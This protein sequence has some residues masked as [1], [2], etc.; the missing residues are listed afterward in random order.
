MK[1]PAKRQLLCGALACIAMSL[2]CHSTVRAQQYPEKLR[3]A[4]RHVPPF[5]IKSKEGNWSGIAIDLWRE[6]ATELDVEYEFKE[7][8]LKSMLARLQSGEVDVA[9]GALTATAK[10]EESIDFTHPFHSSGLGMAV[11]PKKSS[12]VS[13]FSQLLTP[14]VARILGGILVAMLCL[15]VVMYVLERKNNSEQF[16]K[17]IGRG[18]LTGI[19]WA[20]VTMTTVGYGD[21][22]P[23][24]T[25]G[26]LLGTLW[27]FVGIILIAI[28]TGVVSSAL[29]VSKLQSE[30]QGPED[31]P[32]LKIACVQDSTG[33][34]F[35]RHLF[36]RSYANVEEA[37]AAVKSG[38]RG[39]GV[40]DATIL[41][42]LARQEDGAGLLVLPNNF[43]RQDY[44]LATPPGSNLRE[45][46]NRIILRLIA[47]QKWT[48]RIANYLGE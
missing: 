16:E 28:F 10:R 32:R 6:I 31:L 23:K 9:V 44:A 11:L 43:E 45:K 7:M 38:E 8:S 15:G 26:R 25:A 12:G 36:S 41:R 21:K 13:F 29:T 22:V 17:R 20:A 18:L 27:M 40:Y 4:T 14:A 46:C 34:A 1:F 33:A 37:I 39:V 42:Y 3:I 30:V 2:L 5:A 24:S 48:T 35:L 47:E 19:W